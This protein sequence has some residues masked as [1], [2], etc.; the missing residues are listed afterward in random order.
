MSGNP[1]VRFDEGRVGRTARCSPSLLL[2]GRMA[3][4]SAHRQT[5]NRHRV[6]PQGIPAVLDLE[7][8]PRPNRPPTGVAGNP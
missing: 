4:G 6:A 1:L 7:G 8:P 5:G 3:L 2:Y